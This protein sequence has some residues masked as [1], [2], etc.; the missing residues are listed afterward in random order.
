[1]TC[2]HIFLASCAALVLLGT[3][4]GKRDAPIP[5]VPETI[6]PQADAAG[7]IDGV[8]AAPANALEAGEASGK[9]VSLN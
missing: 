6:R 3:A 5:E 2:R 1:M 9:P 4:C 8:I 7:A